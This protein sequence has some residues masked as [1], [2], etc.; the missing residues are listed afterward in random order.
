[1]VAERS[2]YP[3]YS[4][5]ERE[6]PLSPRYLR[7]RKSQSGY[8]YISEWNA[9]AHPFNRLPRSMNKVMAKYAAQP[10]LVSFA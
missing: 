5:Q 2:S 8:R 1:M 4:I 6:M 9:H 10:A 7:R 3:K